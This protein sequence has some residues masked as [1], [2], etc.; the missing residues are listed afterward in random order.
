VRILAYM[1]TIME[2]KDYLTEGEACAYLGISRG[3][4]AKYVKRELIKRYEQKVPRQTLYKRSELDS[5]K[6]IRPKE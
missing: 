3:T 1:E 4:L 5:L 2:K 6:E